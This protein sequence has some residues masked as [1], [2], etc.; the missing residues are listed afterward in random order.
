[1]KQLVKSAIKKSFGAVGY[2]LRR[3]TEPTNH[4]EME[5]GSLLVPSIWNHELFKSLLPLRLKTTEASVVLLGSEGQIDYLR[6]AFAAHRMPAEGIEWNWEANIDFSRF[7]SI[8]AIVICKLPQTEA[9]W[10]VIKELKERHGS[11]VIGIQELVLPFTTILEG[12]ASLTYCVEA[13]E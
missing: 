10:R 4:F 11:R 8:S 9:H 2:E 1:M 7:P 3:K 6:S 12:Q 13:M 5:Q